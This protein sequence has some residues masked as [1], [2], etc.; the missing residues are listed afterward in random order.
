[1]KEEKNMGKES[2]VCKERERRKERRELQE[3]DGKEYSRER[4]GITV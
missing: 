2:L 3:G 4:I 1:M